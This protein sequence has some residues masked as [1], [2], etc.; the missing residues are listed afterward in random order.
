MYQAVS[1][2]SPSQITPWINLLESAITFI[3]ALS[4]NFQAVLELLAQSLHRRRCAARKTFDSGTSSKQASPRSGGG[5][6][7]R[8]INGDQDRELSTQELGIRDNRADPLV[9]KSYDSLIRGG[10]LH[11]PCGTFLVVRRISGLALGDLKT[12]PTFLFQY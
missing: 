12:T 2:K 3:A 1:S 10:S 8:A 4:K 11:L 7:I 9:V 6:A 5:R